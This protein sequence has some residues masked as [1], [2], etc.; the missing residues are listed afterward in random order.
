MW[1]QKNAWM[2]QEV[3]AE[4]A[5]SFCDHVKEHW[6]GHKVLFFCDNLDAH[7][8]DE[9]RSFLPLEM[10]FSTVSHPQ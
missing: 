5:K 4:S 10:C 6:K 2:D 1:F 9:T 3:M 8:C 7:V